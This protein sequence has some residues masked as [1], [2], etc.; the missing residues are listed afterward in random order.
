MT[1]AFAER[2]GSTIVVNPG[3]DKQR[4]HFVLIDMEDVTAM[5]HTIFGRL[6]RLS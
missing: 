4:P 1:K 6:P 2:L 5:E 3:S